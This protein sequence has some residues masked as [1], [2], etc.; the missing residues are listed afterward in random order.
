M[1]GSIY[2]LVPPFAV[3]ITVILTKKI[4]P[5]IASGILTGAMLLN[6]FF[7]GG[8]VETMAYSAAAIF[9]DEAHVNTD[10]ILLLIFIF[11]LGIITSFV[12][13][14]GG[15]VGFARWAQSR[16]K[17][18]AAAQ[19]VAVVL[20]VLIFIDD[21][22]NALT[23]G[24]VARPLT[25]Q[26][27][28]S[29]EKLA[30]LIDS[31]SA[32]VCSICPLSSWGAYIVALFAMIL[33]A[34]AAPLNQFICT[35]PYNFYAIFA[36]AVVFLSAAF[37]VN[38]GKMNDLASIQQA[39]PWEEDDDQEACQIKGNEQASDLVIP[40]LL[41]VCVS[42][43]MMYGTGCISSGSFALMDVLS[44]ASTYFS[45]AVGA[46]AA[47]VFCAI[48]Y[49]RL[50]G[51]HPLQVAIEG[52]RDVAGAVLA[53]L[54]AWIL[55]DI[56]SQMETGTFLSSLMA[57][58]R[59]NARIIPLLL[60]LLSSVMAIA[61]G[62][63]WGVFGMMLPISVQ[64]SQSMDLSAQMLYCCLG[65]VLSGS[66]LG[67]HCSP[68][69]DTTILSSAG[70]KCS[71]VDHVVSQLPYALFSGVIAAVGFFIIG[72]TSSLPFAFAVQTIMLGTAMLLYKAISSRHRR[73]KGND[74]TRTI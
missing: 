5:S 26:H 21:Y 34:T 53:L 13:K 65:A 71:H 9:Y 12:A 36:L 63:S 61:T 28:V 30:Y 3:I 44:C 11:A 43:T 6:G 33:P 58:C 4:I 17:S 48:R 19:V 24:E 18:P 39:M 62:F 60:F 25:D 15:A 54:L 37:N 50:H 14:N 73:R 51:K 49:D 64:I 74:F 67:D 68:I 46:A 16:V 55:I 45:L 56:I 27:K 23:V 35:I 7:P 59:V 1:A 69:A 2:S 20:G 40:I 47:L 57:R 42:M 31:T 70:A 29:R 32:P 22:F 66:V 72:F 10:N 38:I 8:A 52:I 41:L